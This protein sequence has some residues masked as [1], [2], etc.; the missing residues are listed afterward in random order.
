MLKC[1]YAVLVILS[2]TL[3]AIKHLIET[4]LDQC[5]EVNSSICTILNSPNVVA[6]DS[7]SDANPDGFKWSSLCPEY[8]LQPPELPLGNDIGVSMTCCHCI[9]VPKSFRSPSTGIKM[10]LVA[11]FDYGNSGAVHYYDF[12]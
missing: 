11:S 5:K 3:N 7:P 2:C 6:S 10:I 12:P 8:N 1:A 4:A 9:S